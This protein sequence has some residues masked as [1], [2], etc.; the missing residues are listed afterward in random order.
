VIYLCGKC[1]A[2]AAEI[3]V[4]G[5]EVRREAHTGVMFMPVTPE[6]GQRI[7]AALWD[8]AALLAINPELAP[9]WCPECAASYCEDHWRREMVFDDDPLPAWLD[10]IRGECPYGHERMV[11]D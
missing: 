2:R 1:G 4:S 5:G 7:A 3:T 11:E 9:F 10:S 8:P 6:L